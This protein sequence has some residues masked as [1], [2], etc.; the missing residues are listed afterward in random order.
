M[1]AI[2]KLIENLYVRL[3]HLFKICFYNQIFFFFVFLPFSRAAP[4]AYGGSQARDLIRAV[5]SSLHHSL[6]NSGSELRLR[7]TPQLTAMPDP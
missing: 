7:P 6:S 3:K 2:Q 4:A 5:T 1:C